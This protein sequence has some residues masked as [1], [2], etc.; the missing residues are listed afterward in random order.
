MSSRMHRK[1]LWVAWLLSGVLLSGCR[2]GLQA[3][4]GDPDFHRIPE[5]STLILDRP[6]WIG[7]ERVRARLRSDHKGWKLAG[8]YAPHCDL[9]LRDINLGKVRVRPDRFEITRVSGGFT[10]ILVRGKA[11]IQLAANAYSATELAGVGGGSDT[12]FLRSYA[13]LY[14]DSERQPDVYRVSCSYM[15]MPFDVELLTIAEIRLAM[16][17]TARLVLPGETAPEPH[18]GPGPQDTLP[19]SNP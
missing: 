11:P 17:G 18:K 8:E 2:G 5:G 6:V 10:P 13:H 14:L 16:L 12:S 15:G 4:S 3:D 1:R 9:E 7:A 19:A